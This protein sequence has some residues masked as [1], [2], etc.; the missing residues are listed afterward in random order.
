MKILENLNLVKFGIKFCEEKILP[1]VIAYAEPKDFTTATPPL[2]GGKQHKNSSKPSTPTAVIT[3]NEAQETVNTYQKI[4]YSI[5]YIGFVLVLIINYAVSLIF[6]GLRNL[7]AIQEQ[8]ELTVGLI[9]IAVFVTFWAGVA[10]SI[11]RRIVIWKEIKGDE[12]EIQKVEIFAAKV[13]SKKIEKLLKQIKNMKSEFKEEEGRLKLIKQKRSIQDF[14]IM[15]MFSAMMDER[16]KEMKEREKEIKRKS[17]IKTMALSLLSGLLGWFLGATMTY[18]LE[19]TYD[20]W[21]FGTKPTFSGFN[22]Q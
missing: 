6:N 1:F 21:L 9:L 18:A 14:E 7:A 15:K 16:E 4:F 22:E 10:V 8:I 11:N 3:Y 5:I 20:Y 17:N 12:Y 2:F 19:K 13:G